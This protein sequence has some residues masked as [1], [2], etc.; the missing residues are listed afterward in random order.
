MPTSGWYGVG[1]EWEDLAQ[2]EATPWGTRSGYGFAVAGGRFAV[3]G[4]EDSEG[5]KNDVFVSSDGAAWARLHITSAWQA[6]AN[7]LHVVVGDALYVFSGRGC[8]G[9]C[10]DVFRA[11]VPSVGSFQLL[12]QK[13]GE[14]PRPGRQRGLAVP[15]QGRIYDIGGCSGSGC[16]VDIIMLDPD[17]GRWYAVSVEGEKPGLVA[18][19]WTADIVGKW[20]NIQEYRLVGTAHSDSIYIFGGLVNTKALRLTPSS[21]GAGQCTEKSATLPCMA[22]DASGN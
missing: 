22:C 19:W 4:G 21:F 20:P 16:F 13:V 3:F 11:S 10:N 17:S 15:L 14:L 7:F 1:S 5:L 8:G 9:F 18:R 12:F 2:F 6:R